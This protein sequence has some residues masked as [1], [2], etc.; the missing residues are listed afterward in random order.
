M[1][2]IM[3]YGNMVA[4]LALSIPG[5]LILIAAYPLCRTITD[6][7]KKEY[8]PRIMQLSDSIMND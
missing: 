2:L 8:A 3:A 4:G 5:L 7:R 6:K 1:A